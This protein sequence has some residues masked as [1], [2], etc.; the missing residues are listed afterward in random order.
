[1]ISIQKLSS[2]FQLL[3]HNTSLFSSETEARVNELWQAA[4]STSNSRLFN[5]PIFCATSYNEKEI[6]GYFSEYRYLVAQML[7]PRLKSVLN[8]KPVSLLGFLTC[9]D[10][11]LFGK[12]QPWVATRP[13]QWGFLPS[14]LLNPQAFLS[15]G[16]ADYVKAFL[17]HLKEE[18]NI[19][20]H[21]LR[22]LYV[23]SLVIDNTVDGENLS[24]VLRADI[25]LSSLAVKKEHLHAPDDEYEDVIA[26]S[27]ENLREFLSGK[28]NRDMCIANSL[29]SYDSYL[30]LE[31]N[32]A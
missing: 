31:T 21:F 9:N 5:G 4:L 11:V 1:M 26:V 27:E 30:S 22:D 16:R 20:A 14:G 6:K 18:L 28:T 10:G 25:A 17:A 7:D 12:R 15:T 19:E 13:G 23:H 3:Q 29:L 32:C 24:L 8:I 2:E